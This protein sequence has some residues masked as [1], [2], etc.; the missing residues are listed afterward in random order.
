M[1]KIKDEDLA[2]LLVQVRFA[3][4]KQRQKQL[5]RAEELL[6]IQDQLDLAVCVNAQIGGDLQGDVVEGTKTAEVL[7]EMLHCE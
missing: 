4:A 1:R 7:G 5:G 3:P 2:G 6:D